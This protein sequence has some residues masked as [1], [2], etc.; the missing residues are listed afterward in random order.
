VL[1]EGNTADWAEVDIK[2]VNTSL[3]GS[4]IAIIPRSL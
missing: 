2:G 4:T 3:I 1:V